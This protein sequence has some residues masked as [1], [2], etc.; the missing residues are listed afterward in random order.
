LNTEIPP[1][2]I[3]LLACGIFF[4]PK[5]LKCPVTCDTIQKKILFFIFTVLYG[6]IPLDLFCSLIIFVRV[7]CYM[8]PVEEF[9]I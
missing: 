7:Y 2:G 5:G 3:D 4:H 9:Y 8:L 6:Q 1:A